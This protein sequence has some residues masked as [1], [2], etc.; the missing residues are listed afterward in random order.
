M[1]DSKIVR[2]F[3]DYWS[4]NGDGMFSK[5]RIKEKDKLKL[6]RWRRHYEKVELRKIAEEL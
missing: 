4:Y 2:P 3:H 5:D 1:K 6:K